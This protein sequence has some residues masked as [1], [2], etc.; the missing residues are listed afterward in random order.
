MRWRKDRKDNVIFY[1]SRSYVI[2]VGSDH[3][4]II[5]WISTLT[6]DQKDE[7]ASLDIMSTNEPV[8]KDWI[9]EHGGNRY[10]WHLI[11]TSRI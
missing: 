2:S 8:V 7:L 11:V 3:D 1:K 4:N 9:E 6:D 5:S 10:W